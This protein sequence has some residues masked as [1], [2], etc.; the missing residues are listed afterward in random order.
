MANYMKL[1]VSL[2]R[3]Q[4]CPYKPKQVF[5]ERYEKVDFICSFADRRIPSAQTAYDS[6]AKAEVYSFSQR[7]SKA[8]I[9][10]S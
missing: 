1:I 3:L 8:R 2:L 9:A 4:I 10:A 6:S 7:K 5:Y